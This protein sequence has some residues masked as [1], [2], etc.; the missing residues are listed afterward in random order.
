M[1]VN[2]GLFS[3]RNDEYETPPD[4]FRALDREFGFETDVCATPYNAKCPVFYTPEQDG[5]DRKFKL[6]N[7]LS[8][9]TVP[10]CDPPRQAAG[11]CKWSF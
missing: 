10:A 6:P 1:K 11:D 8:C 7:V 5:K 9:P 2:Q 3:S 4:V